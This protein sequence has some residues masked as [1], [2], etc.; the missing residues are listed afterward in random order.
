MLLTGITAV[1]RQSERSKLV[2]PFRVCERG[3]DRRE[4]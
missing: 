2:D 3:G 4:L 1:A